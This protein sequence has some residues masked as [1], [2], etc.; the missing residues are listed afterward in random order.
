MITESSLDKLKRIGF[1]ADI[2]KLESYITDFIAARPVS[3]LTQYEHNFKLL[4]E[5]LKGIKGAYGINDETK[6]KIPF[7][8]ADKLFKEKLNLKPDRLYGY[9]DDAEFRDKARVMFSEN[10]LMD[11]VAV[12]DT[13]G[14]DIVLVY[15]FGKLIRISGVSERDKYYDFTSELAENVK[16]HIDDFED[17]TLCEIRAKAI[18]NDIKRF[19]NPTCETMHRLRLGVSTQDIRIVCDDIMFD[20]ET[21]FNGYWDKLEYLESLGFTVAKYCLLRNIDKESFK[22]ALEE[23]AEF[24]HSEEQKDGSDC[25]GIRVRNNKETTN[26]KFIVRYSDTE[27]DSEQT[28]ESTVKEVIELD[29]KIYL[30]ILEIECNKGLSI[31]KIELEDVFILEKD[32]L[33]RGAR[34]QFKV[35]EGRPIII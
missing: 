23:M 18:V 1:G 24:L 33:K 19:K 8:D 31:D 6:E 26:Y 30:S 22:S 28:F 11:L 3:E 29:G 25:I 15:N 17:A 16:Q 7:D 4:E 34:V 12:S 35:I 14:I 10:E 27:I 20:D 5:E 21:V 13:G 2:N 32:N 9:T